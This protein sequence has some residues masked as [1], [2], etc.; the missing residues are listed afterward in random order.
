MDEIIERRDAEILSLKRRLRAAEKENHVLRSEQ[1]TDSDCTPNCQLQSKT[2][3]NNKSGMCSSV[4]PPSPQIRDLTTTANENPSSTKTPWQKTSVGASSVFEPIH[5]KQLPMS[6]VEEKNRKKFAHVK[7][8]V[9]NTHC[10]SPAPVVKTPQ[11]MRNNSPPKRT[12]RNNNNHH[13][14]HRASLGGTTTIPSYSEQQPNVTHKETSIYSS[15]P[16]FS[17]ATGLDSPPPDDAPSRHHYQS[18]NEPPT[19]PER[20][21]VG[22]KYYVNP[23]TGEQVEATDFEAVA[24]QFQPPIELVQELQKN[25]EIAYER[26]MRD[27]RIARPSSACSNASSLCVSASTPA[28]SYRSSVMSPY[29]QRDVVQYS[30]PPLQTD[31]EISPPNTYSPPNLYHHHYSQ[32]DS[33][34]NNRPSSS[35]HRPTEMF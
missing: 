17:H 25:N 10:E 8:R 15:A 28:T 3:Q 2:P 11:S 30:Q 29:V 12:T 27:T 23:A 24:H 13:N 20:S 34:S 31:D 33:N 5:K 21:Y 22:R 9:Y 18:N 7:P 1:C 14:Q 4:V 26:A 35:H 19:Q 6:V 16:I 32:Y